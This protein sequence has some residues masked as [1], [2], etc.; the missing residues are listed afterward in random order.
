MAIYLHSIKFPVYPLSNKAT[1]FIDGTVINVSK[2]L[3]NYILDDISIPGDSLG[4]RR[5]HIDK[6]LLYPLNRAVM[7]IGDFLLYTKIYKQFIDTNGKLFDYKRRT[8]V[9]LLYRYINRKIPYNGGT[10]LI[11]E[12]IH[13]PMLY[14]RNVENKNNMAVLLYIEKG[15]VL[16]GVTDKP[17]KRTT[18]K[19]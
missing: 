17:S 11:I 14:Y 8:N 6:K 10:M 13:C 15:Y 18:F 19:V 5:L 9:P 1:T 4:K 7:T 12:N 16:L 3:K 2:G